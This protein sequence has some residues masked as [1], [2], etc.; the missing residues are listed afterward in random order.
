M[1]QPCVYIL[2]RPGVHHDLALDDGDS[3][4]HPVC[5]LAI[6]KPDDL[7]LVPF[8]GIG[9]EIL[10]GIKAQVVHILMLALAIAEIVELHLAGILAQH[11]HIYL[12]P[13]I[14]VRRAGVGEEGRNHS[15]IFDGFQAHLIAP[16]AVES[17]AAELAAGV[18]HFVGGFEVVINDELHIAVMKGDREK[19][20]GPKTP[21]GDPGLF[22]SHS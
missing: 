17:L 2:A 7:V 13:G 19:T 3:L 21:S 5:F 10:G 14:V 12:I 15:I 18:G 4:V 8:K 22:P 20:A 9:V 16:V 11:F 6:H 1:I